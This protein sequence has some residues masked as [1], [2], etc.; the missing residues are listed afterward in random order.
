ME[1]I[2]LDIRNNKYQFTQRRSESVLFA[3]AAAKNST[4]R[5]VWNVFNASSRFHIKK[6]E[7]N[8]FRCLKN[9]FILCLCEL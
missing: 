2:N 4:L 7:F 1:T 3:I 6:I 8:F 9:L 5:C